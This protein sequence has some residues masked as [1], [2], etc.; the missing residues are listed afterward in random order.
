[1]RPASAKLC[2]ESGFALVIV[3]WL[4]TVL[5]VLGA[6]FAG[7]MRQDATATKN[8]ADETQSYYLATAAANLT[9]YRAFLDRDRGTRIELVAQ[10]QAGQPGLDEEE[11]Q[12]PL[13]HRDGEW[14]EVE[15]W[16][17]PV[18]VRVTDEGGKIPINFPESAYDAKLHPLLL[19]VLANM[20]VEMEVASEIAD[21][22][23]DWQD[24]DDEHRLNGAESDYYLELPKPYIAKNARL[25]SLEELLLI[26]GVTP[27]LYYGGN[28]E[29][30]IGLRD[31]FTVFNNTGEVNLPFSTPE[32]KRALFGLDDEELAQIEQQVAEQQGAILPILES[33]LPLQLQGGSLVS[34]T[35][36]GGAILTVEAQAQLPSARV[37]AHVG[38]VIDI[39]ESNEGIVVFRWMDQMAVTE[40][41]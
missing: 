31:V 12:G 26:K 36:Q 23:V 4:F 38:A 41:S 10:G 8:F 17:A 13:V 18:M 37:K 6:E 3:M 29:F 5:F 34:E 24:G 1:M 16:G 19:H 22:V 27:E 20:G 40:T 33:R 21:S 14:H 39:E 35:D 2:Q 11:Q 30:P 28:D 32:V 25:D 9:F 7:A 15:L